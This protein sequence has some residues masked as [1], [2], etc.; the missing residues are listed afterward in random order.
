MEKDGK[1]NDKEWTSPVFA[2][3]QKDVKVDMKWSYY[4]VIEDASTIGQVSGQG[5]MR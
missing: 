3:S 5:V 4:D 1:T 2:E